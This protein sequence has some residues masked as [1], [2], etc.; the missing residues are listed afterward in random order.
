MKELSLS[1]GWVVNVDQRR[2]RRQPD[3]VVGALAVANSLDDVILP[4]ERTAGDEIQ[5]LL[6]A[7][8][9]IVAL[10]EGLARLDAG[11]GLGEPGWRIGI[12]VGGV[13][14]VGVRNTREARGPA[15]LVARTAVEAAGTA[16]GHLA[17]R[18]A[19]GESEALEL[20]EAALVLLRSLL[21]RRTR[22]GWEVVDAMTIGESQAV[23]A[24]RLG[25]SES[26]VSQRLARA[27][28]R[29][30]LRG[31]TLAAALLAMVGRTV[32]P[33]A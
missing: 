28:W 12:G 19:G 1:N 24:A 21:A 29:E 22:N 9:P 13:E 10:V 17:A 11:H 23:V 6:R 33:A 30:G 4:F 15:Y 3:R 25:I 16:P 26:A 18:I 14:D 8:E 27:D 31:A 5:G 32:G 2:S 20:A 7:G